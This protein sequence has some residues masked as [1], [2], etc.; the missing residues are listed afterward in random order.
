MLERPTNNAR[1]FEA[2]KHFE[3]VVGTRSEPLEILSELLEIHGIPSVRPI[4]G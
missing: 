4:L 2:V 1:F 3:S